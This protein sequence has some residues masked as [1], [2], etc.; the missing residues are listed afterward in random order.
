M[1]GDLDIV[2]GAAVDVV[3]V[4]PRFHQQLRAAVLP[5]ADRVG[6]EAGRKLGERLSES[7]RASLASDGQRI[8]N[9]LGDAIGDA[10]ARQIATA[11]PNAVR[12]GGRAAQTASRNAGN[13]NAGAFGRAFRNRLEVAFRSLPRPDVRLNDTGFNADL[14]RLRA[15]METLAGKRIGV[16]VDA[17]TAIAEITAIDA[18]LAELGSRSPN[19]Q[20][21]A[22]IMTARAELAEIQRQVNDLDRDDVRIRVTANT[23]QANAALMQLAVSLGVVAAIPLVPI[24]AAGIGAIASAAVAATAGVGAVA[25]A[26]VPAIKSVTSVIQAKNAAEKEAATATN[27]AAA[28]NVRAAQSALQMASAQAAL[29]NAHRQAA[30]Q[31]AQANRQVEDAERALGQAAARAMEQ[32]EQAAERVEDAER[33]LSDAKRQARDAEENLT[34]A[35]EDAARK[36]ADLNDQLERG[37]L[38]ERDATLRV[39]EAQEELNRVTAEYDAGLATELDLE[40][41]QLAFDQATQS[42]KQQSKDYAQLQKDAEAAKKAGVDGNEQVQT[43][44]EQLADAQQNVREQTEAVADANREAAQA[45]VDSAQQIADAQRNLADA[46]TNAADTQV[47]AAES[48]ESAERGIESAR[49]SAID[50]TSKAATKAD[51]YRKALAKL[52]PEQRDLYDSIAG[53]NGLTAAFKAWSKELQPDVLPIFTRAVDGAK[54]SLPGLSP[55]VR[56]SADAIGELMDRASRNLKNPFWQRFKKG[57]AENA[58]PAIVGLGVSFGN[59]FTGMAGVIDAFFPHMQSISERMQAITGRFAAWGTSLRGSPEFERFLDYASEMGPTVA[60]SLGDIGGAFF[61][62]GRA[63]SPLSGPLFRVLGAIA[64]GIATI[65]ENAPWLIQGIWLAVIATKAWTLAM[66]A[67]NFVLNANPIVRIA[68]LIGVLIGAVVLAYNRFGW[69]RTA[70]QVTWKAIQTA[71][72]WAWDNVLKPVFTAIW[73]AIK[74]VGDALVWLWKNIFAPVFEGIWLAA[75]IFV[76][77]L[78]TLV[79]TPIWIAIQAVGAILG[80]LWEAAFKPAFDNMASLAQWVW[81]HVLA[82][83]FKFIWDAL[84]A[85]GEQFLWLYEKAVKPAFNWIADKATWLWANVLQPV[86]GWIWDGVKWLGGGFKWLYDHAV[87]PTWNWISDK[88]DW[89]WDK[90][91]KPAFELIKDGVGLVADAFDE[92]KRMIKSAWDAV[93]GVA[94]KPINWV[95]DFV[96]TKGIK[97][98]WDKVAD[99]VGLNPL[100]KAP[101]LLEAPAKFAEGGRTSGGIPGVDSIPILA[102]ADEFIIKRSSARKIGFDK[103]AY[104]NATGEIPRFADGGIVGALS[105]AWDWAKDTVGGAI[106]KGIDWAKTG[107]DLLANPGK[108]WDKLLKPLFDD[109]RE[110]LDV[111]QFGAML[112]KV[113]VKMAGGLKDMIVDAVTS[114]GGG[115]ASPGGNGGS[116]VARW[117]PTV[118]QALSMTGNPASYADLTLRRMNQESGGNPT[119]VNKWDSN[120]QAGHPSVG[121][122]QVIGPTFRAYAGK[123]RNVG[124]FLYGTSTNPLANVYASMRYAMSAY[125]SLP[126]AYNRPGG[127]ADGG[128]VTPHWYDDGGYLQP[129]LNLVANGTGKPEPVFTSGQWSDIRASKGSGQPIT[130]NVESRTYLDGREVSGIIDERINVYDGEVA[131]DLNNGRWA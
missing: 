87:R 19:I 111:G 46:V 58:K 61:E 15:R 57:I 24:A 131:T 65:A 107:A 92:A 78:V 63:L 69:F 27:N 14:A 102:M 130:V 126:A 114:S 11:L 112:A 91:I 25:L 86:F 68:V 97:A 120:W 101:K 54:K 76:A 122:M 110:R 8:G 28:A 51:E 71:A 79:F 50:T 23:A 59:V 13:D 10:M 30:Q 12:N 98:V 45:Q 49:L 113:P 31:I 88:T 2:G 55:L 94:A 44:A 62:V 95:V 84:K 47:Q 52:T 106:S 70:V 37:K 26:A 16:D 108:I 60:E 121:L 109:V 99:F 33:S 115:G 124:P 73:E 42:A 17:E 103:L 29:R 128:R 89:L 32:R 118:L 39:K 41:A 100:P 75:R 18:Q 74:W 56:N 77:A 6:L 48:I 72:K 125:G 43:A 1:A 104:M 90:G 5:V 64:N 40:R 105:G 123:M 4:V 3:P 83:V 20:V 34:Q 85:Q 127:Y 66:I 119:I 82:P 21:R 9:D 36:L 22:D 7:L 116:G 129:G 80:W 53:P 117:R 67:F 38:D 81:D 96:Y 35:R 93:A